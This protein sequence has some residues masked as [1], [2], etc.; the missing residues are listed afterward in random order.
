MLSVQIG[1]TTTAL[2]YNCLWGRSGVHSQGTQRAASCERSIENAKNV[3]D[4]ERTT[5]GHTQTVHMDI[6]ILSDEEEH[7][8]AHFPVASVNTHEGPQALAKPANACPNE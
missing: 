7:V 3:A 5:G 1:S 2:S 4:T 6:L 8:S